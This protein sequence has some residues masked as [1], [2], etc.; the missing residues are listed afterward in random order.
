M[1]LAQRR[2]FFGYMQTGPLRQLE[3]LSP[4]G[5]FAMLTDQADEAALVAE[6]GAE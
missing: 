4:A 6:Y 5:Q 1:S 2:E 3:A